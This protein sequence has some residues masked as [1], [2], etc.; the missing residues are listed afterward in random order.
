MRETRDKTQG[1]ERLWAGTAAHGTRLDR[2]GAQDK[3]W[4]KK[5]E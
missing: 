2:G 3:T 1:L 5:S 4:E